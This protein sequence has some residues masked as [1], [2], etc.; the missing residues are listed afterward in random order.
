M[1]NE[2]EL[3]GAP[4]GS[5]PITPAPSPSRVPPESPGRSNRHRVLPLPTP[6]YV[7]HLPPHL[8]ITLPRANVVTIC[9]RR[10]WSVIAS[11]DSGEH[12]FISPKSMHAYAS[13]SSHT[14]WLCRITQSPQCRCWAGTIQ[15][16]TSVAL[17][18]LGYSR[19]WVERGGRWRHEINLCTLQDSRMPPQS[20]EHV[21]YGHDEQCSMINTRTSSIHSAFTFTTRSTT[22]V[23][24]GSTSLGLGH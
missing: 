19:P 12:Q 5:G 14:C 16:R 20:Y 10:Q 13:R 4:A 22:R 2:Q 6:R 15:G 3:G 24:V 9:S 1:G 7:T 17:R 8:A 18:L 23:T 11:R 21:S